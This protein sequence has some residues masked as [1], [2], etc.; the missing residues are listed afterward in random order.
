MI[1]KKFVSSVFLAVAYASLTSAF[2]NSE[3]GSTH[4]THRTRDISREFKVEAY[5]PAST[6]EVGP[7]SYSDYVHAWVVLLIG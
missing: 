6:F 5:H 1:S 7:H 4:A 3:G 2:M